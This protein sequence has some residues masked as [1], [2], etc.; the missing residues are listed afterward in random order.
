M[1]QDLLERGIGPIEAGHFQVR[2]GQGALQYPAYGSIVVDE[3]DTGDIIH[4]GLQRVAW[5]RLRRM[6]QSQ[7]IQRCRNASSRLL[8]DIQRHQ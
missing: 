5:F 7:R 4:K 2:L 1:T 3:D 6:S 8:M